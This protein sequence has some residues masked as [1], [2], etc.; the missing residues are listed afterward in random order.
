MT[1]NAETWVWKLTAECELCLQ[2]QSVSL[3]LSRCDSGR[4]SLQLPLP[5]SS[6]S[7]PA[8]LPLRSR[9][10]TMRRSAL[11]RIFFQ[12]SLPSAPAPHP[13]FGPALLYFPLP[14][15]LRSHAL[16]GAPDVITCAKFLYRSVQGFRYRGVKIFNSS[17]TKPVAIMQ[18]VHPLSRCLWRL[19]TCEVW[20]LGSDC[21][22]VNCD[23]RIDRIRRA[24]NYLYLWYRTCQTKFFIYFI[25]VCRLFT[26]FLKFG[27]IL[28]VFVV[29]NGMLVVKKTKQRK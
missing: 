15:Q 14:L 27:Y 3:G 13:I 17:L 7:A 11:N 10:A 22:W 5:L 9:S 8:P 6:R 23:R 4:F 18:A 1:T 16:P 19:W 2:N 25:Y 21:M 12:V 20:S 28:F 24:V 26:S 29:F